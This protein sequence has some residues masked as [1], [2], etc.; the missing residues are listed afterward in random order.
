VPR[1]PLY[2]LPTLT[3]TGAHPSATGARRLLV[4]AGRDTVGARPHDRIPHSSPFS[5]SAAPPTERAQKHGRP[6]TRPLPRHRP[7]SGPRSR[8]PPPSPP[9]LRLDR[10]LRPTEASPSRRILPSA[11]AV[12]PLS[13]ERPPSFAILKLELILSSPS[14]RRTTLSRA[15]LPPSRR[16]V[17][18]LRATPARLA[19]RHPEESLVLSG[20]TSPP[21]SH[22]G[23]STNTPPRRPA[24]G[25][26]VVDARC[27]QAAARLDRATRP[28]PSRLF[29]RL[30]VA[31]RRAPWAV[32]SGRFWP[33][34]LRRFLNV[35]QLF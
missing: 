32:A 11:I 21:V 31:G 6:A 2:S 9:F 10:F 16:P 29:G 35:F 17:V 1:A 22:V 8:A 33:S 15:P 30:C 14:R 24:H 7:R 12:F 13:G 4:T 20:C 5:L 18:R 34:T 3:A 28:R 25:D 19:R 26:H 23:P 27:A